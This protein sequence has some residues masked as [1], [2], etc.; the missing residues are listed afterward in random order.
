MPLFLN[1]RG[2]PTLGIGICDRCS[3]KFP[4]AMLG[5]DPNVPGLMVC[6]ADRDEY[7]PYRLAPLRP[8]SIVLPFTRPD[9]NLAALIED[10]DDGSDVDAN[11]F[12][13]VTDTGLTLSDGDGQEL[14]GV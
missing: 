13:L 9:V 4:L 3:R 12:A 11:I 2:Q 7:D 1:T 8:E 10:A 6:E 14:Y 5:P